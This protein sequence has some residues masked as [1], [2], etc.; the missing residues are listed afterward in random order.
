[1]K[2]QYER[3]VC[4]IVSIESSEI[5]AVSSISISSD[6]NSQGIKGNSN[7]NRGEWKNLWNE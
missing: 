5:L 7:I 1:M 2:K 6:R 3:P 4:G